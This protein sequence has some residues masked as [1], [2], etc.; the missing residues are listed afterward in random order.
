M[1]ANLDEVKKKKI[2]IDSIA[3]KWNDK[4]G[5]FVD[6][7]KVMFN[8]Q[9]L[10][11]AYADVLKAKGANTDGG[12]RTSLDGMN[13]QIIT[14][15]SRSLLDGSWRPGV[16]RRVLIP[17][18]VPG[19]YRSLTVLSPNDKIVAS[20]M[21]IVLNVIFEK[22]AGLSMLPKQ[23]YFNDFSHGF[24]PNRGCH[25]AL[26]VTITWGLIPWFIKADISKCYDTI[27]QKRLLSILGK[28]FADQMM[29][30][31][32]NKL[33]KMR[34]KDVGEPNTSDGTGVP[35]GNPLSSLLANVY[36]NEFDH[37]MESLKK[38]I[39]KSIPSNTFKEWRQTT[40]VSTAELSKATTKKAQSNLR[41]EVYRRKVKDAIKAGIRRNPESDEQQGNRV[42]HRLYY[43]RYADDSLI[44]VKGLK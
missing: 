18:K 34:I 26:D 40:W 16:A 9:T 2:F 3:G 32:L 44:A 31:T 15:L 41:R 29:V 25:S 23:R 5:K 8:P 38:E 22:H 43:V 42:Y 19:E 11:L 21:K 33:F 30:D 14:D 6:I 27:N 20:A 10:I 1:I 35:Q 24:R 37:F 4:I 36:L 17:K 28:S 13:L 7:Y 39:D 12:D